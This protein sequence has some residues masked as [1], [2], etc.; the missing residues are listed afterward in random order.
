MSKHGDI[1][2]A[3]S[4]P[5]NEVERLEALREYM[6]LD[7]LPEEEFEAITSQAQ[8]ICKVPIAIISL[9]DAD[10]QWFKSVQGWDCKETS[11]EDSICQYTVLQ[12]NILEISDLSK[13]PL[14][15]NNPYVV[16][17]GGI[18]FY[19]GVPLTNSKGFSIGT[20]CVI[21][22]Q[23]KV[24]TDEEKTA[25][26][27]LAFSI[28]TLIEA[29]H[30][31]KLLLEKTQK[32]EESNRELVNFQKILQDKVDEMHLMRT[33]LQKTEE[34]VRHFLELAQDM[35]FN[36]NGSGAFVYINPA[37]E[38]IMG[39]TSKELRKKHFLDFIHPD[40]AQGIR[41]QISDDLKN[42]KTN[43]YYEYP[44]LTKN[45]ET[46]WLSM[47]INFIWE[48]GLV[49]EIK[50]F[51]R[52]IT[53]RRL[54]EE[55]LKEKERLLQE[56]QAIAML[57]GW[58]F[59]FQ[60]GELKWTEEVFRIYGMPPRK[61]SVDLAEV[62]KYYLP[63]DQALFTE[64]IEKWRTGVDPE[65]L[66][67][68]IQPPGQEKVKWVCIDVKKI[69]PSQ[70]KGKVYGTIQDITQR[71]LDQIG[72][73]AA[74]QEALAA[75]NA[76]EQFLSTMSHE[77]RTPLNAVLGITQILT[78]EDPKPEQIHNLKTLKFSA[79]NLLVLVNDILDFNK[80]ESGMVQLEHIDFSLEE[81][82]T[83]LTQSFKFKTKE[84]G[85]LL[86]LQIDPKLPEML[87]G[88]PTRLGQIL[89]NLM[90]NALKFTHNGQIKV[91]VDLVDLRGEE[92]KIRFAV[93]DTGIGIAQD[94]LE[95]IFEDFTQA[96]QDTTRKYGGTGL[97]L[98]ISRK[99]VGMM[100][101]EIKVT[102]EEGVGSEFSF[103][104]AMNKSSN[105]FVEKRPTAPKADFTS[106]K[107]LDLKILVAE[108]NEINQYIADKFLTKWGIKADFASDG[109]Q[110]LEKVKKT[111]YDMIL[112]DLQMPVM[113]GYKS[114]VAIR[115]M[116]DP[117][118][119][120]VPIIALTASAIL[121]VQEKVYRAGMTDYLSKP[122]IAEDLYNLLVS[123][124]PEDKKALIKKGQV[125]K[126]HILDV[127]EKQTRGDADYKAQ[128]KTLYIKSFRE[129]QEDYG[130]ALDIHDTAGIKM[131]IHKYKSQI[132]W[133]NLPHLAD[134]MG[135]GLY[136]LESGNFKPGDLWTNKVEVA[137]ICDA[138]IS[139]MIDL[140][141]VA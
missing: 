100:G 3:A 10:R 90:S 113:D 55:L 66:E 104:L 119:S 118:Y 126:D 129:L 21:D 107:S 102:S 37:S 28:I 83:G 70:K 49:E 124:I 112:M 80:L 135:E 26:K 65:R 89:N 72:L 105:E 63:E 62:L 48:N 24:L 139:E 97:G 60:T 40:Y 53:D 136:Y 117:H 7:T 137:Q 61:G 98:S 32:L 58:E 69:R 132:N 13:D 5:D 38:K 81:L 77:I 35:I 101:G 15:K 33:T 2:K 27:A 67:L 42:T 39:Y 87:I 127:L 71:K 4:K 56:T 92:A 1:W 43:A 86:D 31:K 47:N 29:K 115:A 93:T 57:G 6:I 19:A 14:F 30:Q 109:Q 108:D 36:I 123:Y 18:R 140:E 22:T 116:M 11:R 44:V 78:E 52:D 125:K 17:E 74:R 68:Q 51:G 91:K 34:K 120:V 9:M 88:D 50:I 79:N 103:E 73:I 54:A 84:K 94:Q 41:D 141:A 46:V 96:N 59:D 82:V 45:N 75:V 12:N 110:A 16:E 134:L 23:P 111:R 133:L 99:L 95:R 131:L 106:L 85:I 114:S 25:L 64:W 138:I 122:F 20:L 76:R 128:L 121:D 130:N 8:T